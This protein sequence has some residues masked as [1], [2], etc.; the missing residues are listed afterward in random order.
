VDSSTQSV[1]VV[2]RHA[3]TGELIRQGRA[4]HPDGTEVDPAHWLNAFHTAIAAAGGIDD[5]SAISVGGQQHGMVTLDAAGSVIRPALLWNDTRSA[6]SA[7][8]L[9]RELGGAAKAA[10]GCR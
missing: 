4:P 6:K 8:D 10:L 2:I 9:N 1:K 3:E 5:V 7:D